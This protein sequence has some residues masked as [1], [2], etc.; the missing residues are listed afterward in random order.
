MQRGGN[1]KTFLFLYQTTLTE[2]LGLTAGQ[3]YKQTKEGK[4]VQSKQ[5]IHLQSLITHCQ[6][7]IATNM[8][9]CDFTQGQIFDFADLCI[10]ILLVQK[11]N[12]VLV[13]AR[14][15]KR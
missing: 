8:P 13:H 9:L 6:S 10:Q 4:K 12:S 3:P 2:A 7:K 5:A 11:T 15:I 14:T 1:P